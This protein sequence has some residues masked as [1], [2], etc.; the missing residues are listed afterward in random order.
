MP[1]EREEVGLQRE[2]SRRRL[3]DFDDLARRAHRV[4]L[5]GRLHAA[6]QRLLERA[7]HRELLLVRHGLRQLLPRRRPRH[8]ALLQ[9]PPVP[10]VE[11]GGERERLVLHVDVTARERCDAAGADRLRV[12]ELP[13]LDVRPVEDGV[14]LALPYQLIL[15]RLV[16][17]LRRVLEELTEERDVRL[18]PILELGEK[19]PE[20]HVDLRRLLKRLEERERGEE[21]RLLLA[22]L[23]AE[24]FYLVLL[25]FAQEVA[26]DALERDVLV[27]LVE[28]ELA[29]LLL[30]RNVLDQE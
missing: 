17:E 7:A 19:P 14:Q 4:L 24:L 8:H 22:V 23:E 3:V 29:L 12:D 26:N 9:E 15:A 30:R 10:L 2:H 20:R 18:C 11:R 13:P 16:D 28:G 6:D 27:Q 21:E 25:L 1:L 5:V